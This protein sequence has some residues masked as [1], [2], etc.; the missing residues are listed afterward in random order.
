MRTLFLLLTLLAL[1]APGGALRAQETDLSTRNALYQGGL[2]NLAALTQRSPSLRA[3]ELETLRA[4]LHRVIYEPDQATYSEVSLASLILTGDRGGIYGQMADNGIRDLSALDK[5]IL[6]LHFKPLSPKSPPAQVTPL[7]KPL[8]AG[9]SQ[10][11]Q[12]AKSVSYVSATCRK[13]GNRHSGIVEMVKGGTKVRIVEIPTAVGEMDAGKRARIVA[14]RLQSVQKQDPTWW[15]RIT[16]GT[17]PDG[18]SVVRVSNDPKH[19]LM[20]ADKDFA[21]EWNLS[22]PEL[23]AKLVQRIRFTIDDAGGRRAVGPSPIRP[24][25]PS[26]PATMPTR[27]GTWTARRA[28]TGG[29][30]RPLPVTWRRTNS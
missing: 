3:P 18:Q 23:A 20:T 2:S 22:S 19:W 30:L 5:T 29:Q 12:A 10:L 15:N 17:A 11:G 14:E 9:L 13:P 21:S 8:A 7:V 6:N 16:P 25:G 28:T 27:R 24:L 1:T 4:I 26:R